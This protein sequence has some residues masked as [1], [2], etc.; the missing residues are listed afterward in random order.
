MAVRVAAPMDGAAVAA[1]KWRAFGASYRGGVLPD[2][3]LD[4]REIVPPASF[5]TGRA[6]VPPSRRHRLFVWGRPGT[7]F[8]YLDCGPVHS[9]DATPGAAEAGEVYELYV[10]PS[11]QGHGGGTVLLERAEQWLSEVGFAR[12][13]LSVLASNPGAQ[14]F[15]RQR[16]WAPTGVVARVDL[17]TV[18]F[19]EARFERVSGSERPVLPFQPLPESE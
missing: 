13:E 5:W 16:G 2:A 10:D 6:M 17:G 7:V 9:D 8:G 12:Q 14:A 11:A 19:D 15:Y 18:A 3:F 1:V 4:V